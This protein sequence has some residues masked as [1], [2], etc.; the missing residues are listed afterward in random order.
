[1]RLAMRVPETLTTSR[2]LEPFTAKSVYEPCA[3][4][5]DVRPYDAD[6]TEALHDFTC[7]DANFASRAGCALRPT[8]RVAGTSVVRQPG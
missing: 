6:R 3:A 5:I 8:K 2:T 4:D 7:N 1:M